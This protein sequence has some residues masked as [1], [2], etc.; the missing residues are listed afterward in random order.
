MSYHIPKSAA[1]TAVE[2]ALSHAT[3]E[4]PL[5]VHQIADIVGI[6]IREAQKHIG[7]TQTAGLC[8]N[9]NAGQRCA[10][11]YVWG[12]SPKAAAIERMSVLDRDTYTGE[13]PLP[14]RDGALRAFELPSL[15][16]TGTSRPRVRPIIV[17]GLQQYLGRS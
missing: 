15:D 12:Q 11:A 7:N 16:H 6:E 13:R 4:N 14:L 5:T 2:S 17:G 10:G 3:Y 9:K 1:R 8:W